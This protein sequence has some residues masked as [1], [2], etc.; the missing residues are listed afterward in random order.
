MNRTWRYFTEKF[1]VAKKTPTIFRGQLVFPT[2]KKRINSFRLIEIKIGINSCRLSKFFVQLRSPRTVDK[3]LEALAGKLVHVASFA[4][5]VMETYINLLIVPLTLETIPNSPQTTKNSTS[6][7]KL[8]FRKYR[9]TKPVRLLFN[10]I[11]GTGT[12]YVSFSTQELNP[13]S[14]L[15]SRKPNKKTKSG[16]FGYCTFRYKN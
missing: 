7:T 1:R 14:R 4:Q 2:G 8:A 10:D 9:T 12:G 11:F 6:P 16:I 15:Q 13:T 3:V 5:T